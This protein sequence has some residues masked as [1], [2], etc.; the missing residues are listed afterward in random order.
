MLLLEV[1]LE[2]S[3]IKTAPIMGPVIMKVSSERN[4]LLRNCWQQLDLISLKKA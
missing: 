1:V 2:V 4:P 3:W